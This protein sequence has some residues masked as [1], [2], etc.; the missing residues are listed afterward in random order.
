MK[1]NGTLSRNVEIQWNKL[2][3]WGCCQSVILSDVRRLDTSL[4]IILFPK[5]VWDQKHRRLYSKGEK[6]ELLIRFTL[7]S[8]PPSLPPP[9]LS[10]S[11]T[12]TPPPLHSPT[13]HTH[14]DM[15]SSTHTYMQTYLNVCVCMCVRVC[16]FA[17]VCIFAFCMC[18]CM[19]VCVCANVLVSVRLCVCECVCVCVCVCIC[20][21][22]CANV[23]VSVYIKGSRPEW[24]NSSMIYSSDTPFW[25]ETLDVYPYILKTVT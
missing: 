23:L 1:T 13:T 2:T 11:L 3:D 15:Y 9:S 20:M 24:C 22:V 17:C 16:M 25:L 4:L 19:H 5:R 18:T 10:L 8:P 21:C 14:T 12:H 6:P 7:T